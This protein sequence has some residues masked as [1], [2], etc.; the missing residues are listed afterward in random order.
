[1]PLPKKNFPSCARRG[2][3]GLC[4]IPIQEV[5]VSVVA[6]AVRMVTKMSITVFQIVL[7]IVFSLF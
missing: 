7:S 6:M 2:N 5:V 1:M 3:R 4:Y